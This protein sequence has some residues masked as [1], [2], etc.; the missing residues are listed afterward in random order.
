M[1][2][3]FTI[4]RFLSEGQYWADIVI[5]QFE[6]MIITSWG[7]SVHVGTAARHLHASVTIRLKFDILDN[8]IH[9]HVVSI[10][11][12]EFTLSVQL[13]SEVNVRL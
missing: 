1:V 7:C 5:A 8:L 6:G 4:D 10:Y 13:F 11:A 2:F 3:N 9:F 12:W